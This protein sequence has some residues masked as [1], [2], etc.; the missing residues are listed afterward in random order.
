MSLISVSTFSPTVLLTTRAR[1]K[2]ELEITASTWDSLL[3]ELLRQ[4]SAAVETYC[5]RIFA[6]QTYSETTGAYG[7]TYLSLYH[8][9]I[10][11]LTSISYLGD[12][13]TDVDI[14]SNE[15]GLLYRENGFEWTTLGYAGL[16]AA[17]GWLAHGTPQPLE[18]QP[19]YVAVYTAGFLLPATNL[20]SVATVS[21]ASADNSFNDSASGF[22]SLLKAGDIIETSGFTDAANNGRYKVSGTP[23]TAKIIVTG[24]TTLVLEAAAAGRTVLL[25]TLPKDVETAVIATTKSYFATRTVDSSIVERH[26]GPIGIRMAENRASGPGLP[27][28]AVG[29]LRPWVRAR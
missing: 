19:D 24:G 10:I 21:A 13:L 3:D 4:A 18:E 11:T 16:S 2:A 1:V 17:G 6:R 22:P 12:A 26:A 27:P 29:L 7:G 23:T 25:Q 20:L 15:E 14:G 8:S 5:H 9:P 28:I